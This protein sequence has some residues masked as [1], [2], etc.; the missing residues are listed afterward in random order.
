MASILPIQRR[1]LTTRPYFPV[2]ATF[3]AFLSPTLAFFN[4]LSRPPSRV[5]LSPYYPQEALG[6]SR[7]PYL[8]VAP[9]FR[10]YGLC[11]L[12][13]HDPLHLYRS[14]ST[15]ISFSPRCPM[16]PATPPLRPPIFYTTPINSVMPLHLRTLT[17]LSDLTPGDVHS[18]ARVSFHPHSAASL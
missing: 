8:P 12:I 10:V 11:E 6:F 2:T 4:P 18:P 1:T 13:H 15:P 9:D 7:F 3:S 16:P 17:L 14:T 5:G